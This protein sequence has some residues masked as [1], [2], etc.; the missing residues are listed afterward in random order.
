MPY[1]EALAARVREVL[2]PR[3]DLREQPMFGGLS[4]LLRGHM[5]CGILGDAL[6]VRV[7]REAYD[8]ALERPH[9][10]PMVLT[11]RPM[12]GIV[13][14]DAAGLKTARTLRAWV[15]RGVAYAETLPAKTPR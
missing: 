9:C 4:L 7:G 3:P 11:G 14:V 13:Q 12:R 5:A 8:A 15:A 1:D 2:G 10:Q 6:V